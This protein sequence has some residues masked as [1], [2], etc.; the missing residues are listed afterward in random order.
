MSVEWVDK[1]TYVFQNSGSS[2]HDSNT[3][4]KV[5]DYETLSYLT[6]LLLYIWSKDFQDNLSFASSRLSKP[7]NNAIMQEHEMLTM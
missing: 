6:F 7:Y 2:Y 5:V 3:V 1:R 4:S